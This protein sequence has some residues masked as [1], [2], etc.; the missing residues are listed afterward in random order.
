MKHLKVFLTMVIT[1]FSFTALNARA[2]K[3][4]LKSSPAVTKMAPR[5]ASTG[6]TSTANS[7]CRYSLMKFAIVGS[8]IVA[9]RR[10]R[11]DW[12]TANNRDHPATRS[13]SLLTQWQALILHP[14]TRRKKHEYQLQRGTDTADAKCRANVLCWPCWFLLARVSDDAQW[15]SGSGHEHWP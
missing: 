9:A 13:L 4:K 5:N 8:E 2:T 12:R 6:Q 1:V 11:R 10:D 15:R 7:L 3:T 14:R